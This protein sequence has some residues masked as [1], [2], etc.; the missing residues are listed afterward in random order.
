MAYLLKAARRGGAQV[1]PNPEMA[2]RC[3]DVQ[4]MEEILSGLEADEI[5]FLEWKRVE[6]ERDGKKVF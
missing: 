4:K 2:A 5:E 1:T 3:T 6:I